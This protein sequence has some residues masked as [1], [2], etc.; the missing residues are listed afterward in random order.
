M[1][2]GEALTIKLEEKQLHTPFMAYIEWEKLMSSWNF[3]L[4]RFLNP[5]TGYFVQGI[6]IHDQGHPYNPQIHGS[7]SYGQ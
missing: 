7:T 2:L 3:L 6:K 5:P 1:G 4:S